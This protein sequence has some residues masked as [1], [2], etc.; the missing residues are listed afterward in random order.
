MEKVR[1][2]LSFT[3]RQ[4][5]TDPTVGRNSLILV[6]FVLSNRATHWPARSQERPLKIARNWRFPFLLLGGDKCRTLHPDGKVFEKRC[7]RG[8]RKGELGKS[9]ARAFV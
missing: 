2:L 7:C 4:H 1:G 9:T 5:D 8:Q 3:F 6:M